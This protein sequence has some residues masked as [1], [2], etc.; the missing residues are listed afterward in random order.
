[1]S[2]NLDKLNSVQLQSLIKRANERSAELAADRARDV[3]DKID[4]L[5]ARN[6]LSLADVYPRLRGIST[7]HSSRTRLP[8]KYKNPEG[9]GKTWC[10]RGKQP[11]WYKR[12][13]KK[14]SKPENML[15]R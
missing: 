5:L 7:A 14:G 2:L 13:I 10:G 1:M 4:S 9:D 15:I 12:A 11:D 8:P 6:A 3:R